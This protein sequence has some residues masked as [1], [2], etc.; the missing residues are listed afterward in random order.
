MNLTVLFGETVEGDIRAFT[1]LDLPHLIPEGA[2]VALTSNEVAV[3]TVPATVPV[4]VG[5]AADLT[6]DVTILAPGSTDIHV[7]LTTPD[8]TFE[9]TATLTVTP[10]PE[11]GI[12]KVTLTLRRKVPT[13]TPV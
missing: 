11:P 13:P 12:A 5:G 1:A 8:G 3:A 6:F 4:P 2:T 10:A 9:D 7:V